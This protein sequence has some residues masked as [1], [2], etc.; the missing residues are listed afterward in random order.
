MSDPKPLTESDEHWMRYALQEAERAAAKDEVPVGALI[1]AGDKQLAAAHN[2]VIGLHD[3]SA[4]AEV[5]ALRQAA[6]SLENYRLPDCTLFVTIE[7]C[8][9]CLGALVHARIKRLVY[10]AMEPKAGCIHS[11][12]MLLE[13]GHFNHRFDVLGG[14]LAE[15]CSQA[16]SR[17]FQARRAK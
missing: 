12:P 16:M 5:L 15:E 9:M 7:P 8:A 3:P 13:Q 1:V 11:H 17:F 6:L 4:H 14:V 2:Q 10:G